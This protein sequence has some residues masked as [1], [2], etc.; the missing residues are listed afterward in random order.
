MITEAQKGAVGTILFEIA[1]I[2]AQEAG[3]KMNFPAWE[4]LDD[5]IKA[6]YI[7]Y[8]ERIVT[9]LG[10]PQSKLL[11]SVEESSET[12]SDEPTQP[13]ATEL[14]PVETMA[15]EESGLLQGI[16]RDGMK[17]APKKPPEKPKATRKKRAPRQ[18]VTTG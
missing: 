9:A 2:A 13:T 4:S 5:D 15:T 11:P 6:N 12:L 7:A 18:K 16:K 14:P 17:L 3:G 10:I 1:T 8:A